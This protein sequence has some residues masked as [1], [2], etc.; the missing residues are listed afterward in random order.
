MPTKHIKGAERRANIRR[1]AA[2]KKKRK[3]QRKADKAE[4]EAN[5]KAK[6]CDGRVFNFR[7]LN[8]H[9]KFDSV[10][11]EIL[12]KQEIQKA[13]DNGMRYGEHRADDIESRVFGDERRVRFAK[14]PELFYGAMK[15]I[16]ALEAQYRERWE[17]ADFISGVNDAVQRKEFEREVYAKLENGEF[18]E[19]EAEYQIKH[20]KEVKEQERKDII[21]RRNI[22]LDEAARKIIETPDDVLEQ[23]GREV[24]GERGIEGIGPEYM[25]SSFEHMNAQYKANRAKELKTR[26]KE[27]NRMNRYER[28]DSENE[29][30]LKMFQANDEMLEYMDMNARYNSEAV[31]HMD[32][33]KEQAATFNRAKGALSDPAEE[34]QEIEK[35][36]RSK[37]APQTTKRPRLSLSLDEED[38]EPKAPDGEKKEAVEDKKKEAPQKTKRQRKEEAIKEMTAE[39][40]YSEIKRLQ[41]Q[42]KS[43]AD[44]H[45]DASKVEW[46][47]ISAD[48][49]RLMKCAD[50]YFDKA[51]DPVKEQVHPDYEKVKQA[52]G[53][54]IKLDVWNRG[55]IKKPD[56]ISDAQAYGYV[57]GYTFGETDPFR[58]AEEKNRLVNNYEQDYEGALLDYKEYTGDKPLDDL[59]MEDLHTNV[60]ELM[61]KGNKYLKVL[62]NN[63][64]KGDSKERIKEVEDAMTE[65][66]ESWAAKRGFSPGEL[67]KDELLRLGSKLTPT[68]FAMNLKSKK[69]N[70]LYGKYV[71]M[72]KR[73][74]GRFETKDVIGHDKEHKRESGTMDFL[75]LLPAEEKEKEQGE[76]EAKNKAQDPELERLMADIDSDM[77]SVNEAAGDNIENADWDKLYAAIEKLVRDALSFVD[78]VDAADDAEMKAHIPEVLS[79]V[80]MAIGLDLQNRNVITADDKLS[81]EEILKIMRNYKPGKNARDG[82]VIEGGD[83]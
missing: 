15:H 38:T 60:Y 57:D 48:A 33:I 41:A 37:E 43:L 14:S 22:E 68:G 4:R 42:I 17:K 50:S 29:A 24:M 61:T 6:L 75:N 13:I 66:M 73:N 32:K 12:R 83:K 80:G 70:I 16:K 55:L 71:R 23:E 76:E 10:S 27:R 58:K 2:A 79:K 78:R 35:K 47:K 39:N 74:N 20:I 65:A 1:L 21:R 59:K 18:D 56:E 49:D 77:T 25:Q 44:G 54:V 40:L 45:D 31:P 62:R 46:G 28:I 67:T 53:F 3:D 82:S 26:K 34:K 36:N 51:A 9:K 7:T 52:V 72:N 8:S 19:K 5:T 11:S 30:A 63:A 69:Q 64:K 81:E